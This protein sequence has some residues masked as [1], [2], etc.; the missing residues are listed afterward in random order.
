LQ[1]KLYRFWHWVLLFQ[2]VRRAILEARLLLQARV[3]QGM[4]E[5]ERDMFS[6]K[7]QLVQDEIVKEEAKLL[8]QARDLENLEKVHQAELKV[9]ILPQRLIL[10]A[11]FPQT[12]RPERGCT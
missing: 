5:Q 2:L 12:R 1:G 9:K 6:R 3:Q 11:S 7:L 4:Q 10:K 8:S